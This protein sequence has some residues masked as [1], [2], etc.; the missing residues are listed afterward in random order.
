[1]VGFANY[2]AWAMVD[3]MLLVV[4]V[5]VRWGAGVGR[6]VPSLFYG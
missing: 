3:R 5:S 6:L 2:D 1:M 4:P